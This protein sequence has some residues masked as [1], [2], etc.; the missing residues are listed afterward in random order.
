[1]RGR[2]AVITG[3]TKGLGR[4][5]SVAFANAGYRVVGLYSTDD[6]AAN[7]LRDNLQGTG[8]EVILLKH[9][10]TAEA[11]NLWLRPEIAQ[12]SDLV[13]INNAC[14]PF[15]PSPFHLLSWSQWEE[16]LNVG[17]KGSWLC[18]MGALKP[19]LRGNGGTIVNVLSNV[20]HGLPPKGFSAYVT[21]K[22]AIRG[23]TMALASEYSARGIRIFSVSP[24]FMHTTL[25]SGWDPSTLASIR[26]DGPIDDP[27][28]V[29][30]RILS[31]V[32]SSETAGRGE[33]YSTTY[34]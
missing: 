23:L 12:A 18:S 31:L 13:L 1:M 7:K 29:A 14:A 30:I 6:D 16:G 15:S 22:Y 2:T 11:G 17:L 20:V 27:S 33:D 26:A 21:V 5:T 24:R 34:E 3:A 9:D 4:A 32:E 8:A 10:V 25:T 19:M 28:E